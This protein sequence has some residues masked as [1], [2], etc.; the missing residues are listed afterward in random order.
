LSKHLVNCAFDRDYRIPPGFGLTH[1][2]S[3]RFTQK[4]RPF[5]DAALD[6]LNYGIFYASVFH[7]LRLSESL[8]L[9]HAP[10]FRFSHK[11]DEP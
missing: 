7:D 3:F 9:F 5:S 6:A 1:L 4:H 11:L 2:D 8:F 10:P